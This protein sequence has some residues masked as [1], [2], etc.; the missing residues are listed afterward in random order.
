MS[1]AERNVSG[2]CRNVAAP[3]T[4]SRWQPSTPIPFENDANM[5]PRSANED[6]Q[7]DPAVFAVVLS[8]EREGEQHDDRRLDGFE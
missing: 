3:I 6:E 1:A 7:Q 8:A 4:V 2:S 5:A